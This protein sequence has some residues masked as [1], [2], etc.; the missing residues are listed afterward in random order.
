MLIPIDLEELLSY[1]QNIFQ[2]K[3]ASIRLLIATLISK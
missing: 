3:T 2:N 1:K